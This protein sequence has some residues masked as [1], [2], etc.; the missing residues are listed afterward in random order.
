MLGAMR[1]TGMFSSR[2]F[3]EPGRCISR[4]VGTSWAF[5]PFHRDRGA[6]RDA[7]AAH[8]AGRGS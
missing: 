4:G 7:T 5:A 8:S 1:T 2:S 3:L 6:G